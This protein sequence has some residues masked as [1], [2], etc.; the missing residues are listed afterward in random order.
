[1]SARL[2]GVTLYRLV[3]Y[4]VASFIA[5]PWA[6]SCAEQSRLIEDEF[7]KTVLTYARS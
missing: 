3:Q 2:A 4:Y 5:H 7:G 6:S 1:L